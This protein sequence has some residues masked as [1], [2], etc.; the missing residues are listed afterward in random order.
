MHSQLWLVGKVKSHLY[1]FP[2]LGNISKAAGVVQVH[3]H[4]IERTATLLRLGLHECDQGGR[5]PAQRR[6]LYGRKTRDYQVDPA[7]TATGSASSADLTW[8]L[9]ADRA[10]RLLLRLGVYL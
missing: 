7:P 4:L 2:M 3:G 9:G 1:R 10:T 5:S 6:A 8:W